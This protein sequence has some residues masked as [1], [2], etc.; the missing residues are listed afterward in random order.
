MQIELFN[1]ATLFCVVAAGTAA[2]I[3]IMITIDEWKHK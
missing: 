2:G 1:W 3:F